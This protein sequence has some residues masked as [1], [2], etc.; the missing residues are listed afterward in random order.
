MDPKDVIDAMLAS[1]VTT[2]AGRVFQER[3]MSKVHESVG[4]KECSFLQLFSL[5]IFIFH[6]RTPTLVVP[7]KCVEAKSLQRTWTSEEL[8]NILVH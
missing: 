2:I 4:Q 8:T 3:S 6:L 1:N 5:L 7:E